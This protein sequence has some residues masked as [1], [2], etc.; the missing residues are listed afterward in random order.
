LAVATA[1]LL[2]APVAHGGHLLAPTSPLRALAL[3]NLAERVP[4]AFAIVPDAIDP[5]WRLLAAASSWFTLA[6]GLIT[7]VV[8]AVSLIL[9][10]ALGVAIPVA[11]VVWSLGLG[12]AIIRL[13]ALAVLLEERDLFRKGRL[14]AELGFG[15]DGEEEG[16]EESEIHRRQVGV[17]EDGVGSVDVWIYEGL[18]WY[19]EL[20]EWGFAF[21]FR[22]TTVDARSSEDVTRAGEGGRIHL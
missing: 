11:T 16:G 7:Y 20:E 14:L 21:V 17:S 18:V 8:G 6:A 9:A 1:D 22:D 5:P 3:G 15:S 13:A 2:E 19:V 12:V 10:A 4:L